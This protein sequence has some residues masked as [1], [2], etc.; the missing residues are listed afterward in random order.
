MW[1][2]LYCCIGRRAKGLYCL[3]YFVPR[4]YQES[5]NSK[6]LDWKCLLMVHG[7]VRRSLFLIRAVLRL[8]QVVPH[9]AL[10][11]LLDV[12]A[13]A[14][15]WRHCDIAALQRVS[16]LVVLKR[17]GSSLVFSIRCSVETV[18]IGV[19]SQCA[20]SLRPSCLC[21][22]L[23][24]QTCLLFYFAV[25]MFPLSCAASDHMF[26][27]MAWLKACNVFLTFLNRLA[28]ELRSLTPPT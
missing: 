22:W 1:L 3:L 2:V 25:S 10:Q 6:T 19:T 14:H 4:T 27:R 15:H 28:I 9:E 8:G 23:F 20:C 18:L 7:L 16:W 17:M 26:A 24:Q 21:H 12:D 11:S 5:K 13:R